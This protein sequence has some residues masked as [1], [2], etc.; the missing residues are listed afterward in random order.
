MVLGFGRYRLSMVRA[1]EY[2]SG[3]TW[4]WFDDKFSFDIFKWATPE[5]SAIQGRP[6]NN[7]KYLNG[8][9]SEGLLYRA[10]S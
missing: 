5:R 4:H 9:L 7:L 10:D 6:V 3:V 1:L 2:F 8:P